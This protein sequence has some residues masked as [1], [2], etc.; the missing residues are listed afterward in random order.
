M[1]VPMDA[2]AQ[3]AWMEQWRNAAMALEE[4]RKRELRRLSDQD[5]LAASEAVL[6]LALLTPI[7]SARLAD[8][9]LVRQQRLFH[10]RSR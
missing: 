3:R 4:Q 10:R 9:G 1:R 6:S 2:A 5:A 8:S 7:P